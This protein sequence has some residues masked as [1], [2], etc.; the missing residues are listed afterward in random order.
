[1]RRAETCGVSSA[2]GRALRVAAVSSSPASQDAAPLPSS[3]PNKKPARGERAGSSKETLLHRCIR[4][5][6]SF[7]GLRYLTLS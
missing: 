5:A 2:Q 4:L 3:P 1:M 6:D 7:R